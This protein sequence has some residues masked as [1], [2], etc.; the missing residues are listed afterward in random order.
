MSMVRP[1]GLSRRAP[2]SKVSP[3]PSYRMVLDPESQ[4][5]LCYMGDG[6]VV[7]A[8]HKKSN[9]ATETKTSQ[10]K[11]DG[12]DHKQYD[13]DTD[14]DSDEDEPVR[15]ERPVLVLSELDDATADSVIVELQKRDVPVMRLDPGA[16]FPT[17]ATFTAWLDG[18]GQWTGDLGMPTRRLVLGSVRAVYRRRPSLHKPPPNLEP[19]DADFV[20]EEARQGFSGILANLPNRLYVNHPDAN[21]SAALK[22]RQLAVAAELGFRVPPSLVTNDPTQARA[23]AL[24]QGQIIYKPLTHVRHVG[25]EGPLTIWTQPVH[26]DELDETIAGTAHLF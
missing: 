23:F 7:T 15:D 22:V 16:D 19:Q 13:P 1:W 8:K 17:D 5:G 10:N 3:V 24:E 14:Q 21:R 20:A 4:T 6:S 18:S 26:A 25:A 9:R 2:F 12:G 11:G